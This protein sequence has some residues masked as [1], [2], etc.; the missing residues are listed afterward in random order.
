MPQ[1]NDSR[2]DRYGHTSLTVYQQLK[3]YHKYATRSVPLDDRL[4]LLRMAN[5]QR[6]ATFYGARTYF[7]P[8]E[9]LQR[10]LPFEFSFPSGRFIGHLPHIILH[11]RD[12]AEE[13]ALR[14]TINLILQN[15]PTLLYRIP[16]HLGTLTQAPISTAGVSEISHCV[17]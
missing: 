12:I 17:R 8:T 16:G 11:S 2:G 3:N 13:L 15:L 7:H 9:H 6:S 1:C 5:L 4:L 10:H 14:H